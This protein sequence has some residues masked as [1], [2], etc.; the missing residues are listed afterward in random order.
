MNKNTIDLTT[1][2]KDLPHGAINEIAKKA[3]VT[4]IT[5][6][7]AFSGDTRSPKLP[8]VQKAV[9]E[10]ITEWKKKKKEAERALQTALNR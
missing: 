3:G 2:R 6:S 7:R 10:F 9:A 1:I 8:E 4:N 5:V